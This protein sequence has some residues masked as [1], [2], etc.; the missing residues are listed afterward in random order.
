MVWW[1][2]FDRVKDDYDDGD[3]FGDDYDDGNGDEVRIQIRP[4]KNHPQSCGIFYFLTHSAR[5]RAFPCENLFNDG[6]DNDDD[7]DYN[8][9]Y[10]DDY[11]NDY[12]YDDGFRAILLGRICNLTALNISIFNAKTT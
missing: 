9:N 4:S 1:V 3:D 2:V 12:N 8:Y 11:D 6:D 5:F 10:D 7:Y